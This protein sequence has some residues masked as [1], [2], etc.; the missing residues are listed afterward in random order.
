MERK[1]DLL[2][3]KIDVVFHSLFRVGNEDITKAIITAITKE[4]IDRI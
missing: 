3:T 4:K 2:K 1:R